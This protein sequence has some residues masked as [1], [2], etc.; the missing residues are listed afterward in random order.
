M[1]N[2]C[3]KV[4]GACLLC[5]RIEPLNVRY[6]CVPRYI[7]RDRP[8]A[9]VCC[10]I[11]GKL[12]RSNFGHQYIFVMYDVFSKFTKIY[13]MKKISTRGCLS[14]VVKDYM[15]KYG[16]ITA[17]LSD[18]ASLFSSPVW[19]QTLEEHNVKCYHS[20][21]YHPVG[22][23][24]ERAL[25]NVKIYLRAYCHDRHKSWYN[26]CPL[27]E[28]IINRSPNPSTEVSP[29]KLMT[30]REPESLFEGLPATVP[31]QGQKEIDERQIVYTKLKKRAEERIKRVRRSK[32]RW[33]IQVGEQ[34]LARQ[35]I[36]S[37]ALKGRSYKLELL[38]SGPLVVTKQFGHDTYELYD[39]E[40]KKCMGRYH[41]SLLKRYVK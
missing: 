5:Q 34:V 16:P 31:V 39:E 32:K 6:D 11:H 35:H 10:D 14:K 1:A 4:I 23:A 26:V 3:R 9:L 25:R 22:N 30:G 15:P 13:P 41:K 20:S 37:N 12:P 21:V 24:C 36:L 7:L 19:R 18:N 8:N 17:L 27:I 40:K 2:R 33:N 38:Y 29:E 28:A